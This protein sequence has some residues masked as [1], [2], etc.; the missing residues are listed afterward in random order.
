MQPGEPRGTA[1]MR[2]PN[3]RLGDPTPPESRTLLRGQ[4][5]AGSEFG[6]WKKA[7]GAAAIAG[8]WFSWAR[9]E[10]VLRQAALF[11]SVSKSIGGIPVYVLAPYD[12][13]I[14]SFS[15][16]MTHARWDRE[17]STVSKYGSIEETGMTSGRLAFLVLFIVS[18][19]PSS[20]P[21]E[22]A[23]GPQTAT[24]EIGVSLVQLL[25][26][27]ARYEGALIDVTGYLD[28]RGLLFLTKDH[29]E[30][31]DLETAIRFADLTK[32][33]QI[34]QHCVGSYARVVGT[35]GLRKDKPVKKDDPSFYVLDRLKRVTTI[36]EGFETTTC[37]RAAGE[38]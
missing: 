22:S 38:Q 14:P 13:Q 18:W 33:G 9:S 23:S 3:G 30:V 25:A 32:E 28:E 11:N 36:K 37:W 8:S 35:F 34:L 29:A 12:K 2:E 17:G 10:A 20:S 7:T 4:I 26:T 1:L 21:S 16:G 6:G 31:F 24:D 27:P 19:S 15:S 5:F